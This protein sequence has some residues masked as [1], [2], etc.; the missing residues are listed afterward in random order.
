MA[1]ATREAGT[2]SEEKRHNFFLA[3]ELFEKNG[4]N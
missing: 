2:I 4:S 1:I 3:E